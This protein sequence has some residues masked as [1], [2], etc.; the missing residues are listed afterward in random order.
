MDSG[1]IYFFYVT[2]TKQNTIKAL[3]GRLP[4]ATD[5]NSASTAQALAE[6]DSPSSLDDPGFQNRVA[7]REVGNFDPEQGLCFNLALDLIGS[8]SISDVIH[9]FQAPTEG[10][11]S[12]KG[13][14]LFYNSCS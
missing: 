5:A 4:T 6:I 1:L 10:N 12:P 9:G 3:P 8:T 7:R 14:V 13:Q 11:S 2:F